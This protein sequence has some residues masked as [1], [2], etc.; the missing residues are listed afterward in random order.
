MLVDD[1]LP[2]DKNLLR[3]TELLPLALVVVE[4][5]GLR[6][7]KDH[8]KDPFALADLR[9]HRTGLPSRGAGNS[10]FEDMAPL[11]DILAFRV[12]AHE[13]EFPDSHVYLLD[14]IYTSALEQ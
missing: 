3:G 4:L 10:S 9:N 6:L 11:G 2:H 14:N 8:M 1:F 13:Y 12:V 5:P 7:P